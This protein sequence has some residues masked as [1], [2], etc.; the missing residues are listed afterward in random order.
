MGMAIR[1]T[2]ALSTTTMEARKQW[3]SIFKVM[4]EN[5][6]R[7]RVGCQEKLHS[8][9]RMDMKILYRKTEF[10]TK[11]L[12]LKELRN[13]VLQGKANDDRNSQRCAKK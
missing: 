8:R 2:A 6:Y 13:H 11:R 4:K 9:M 5:N 7:P 10:T 12:A 3:D 1:M